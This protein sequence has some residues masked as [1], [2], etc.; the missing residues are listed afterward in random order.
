MGAVDAFHGVQ[1]QHV[2]LSRDAL[3]SA[4]GGHAEVFTLA[5][6]ERLNRGA[7]AF[8][9]AVYFRSG[10]RPRVTDPERELSERAAAVFQRAGWKPP[11][12]DELA[13]AVRLPVERASKLTRYLEDRGVLVR[14]DERVVMHLDAVE[15]GKQAALALFRRAP[16]FTTMA[17]RD[18]LGVSRKFAVPLLDHLDRVRFTARRGHDRS[19]GAEARRLL[20]GEKSDEH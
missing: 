9:G 18:A 6:E 4:V 14:L 17:F 7:L 8:N 20:A 16:S 19:P 13:A 10:W 3:A 11:T 2:G 5:L 12:P 1:A 15:A